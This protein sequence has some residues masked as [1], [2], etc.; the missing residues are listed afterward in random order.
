MNKKQFGI[1]A[2]SIGLSFSLCACTGSD[3]T[4]RT[5]SGTETGTETRD[6]RTGT[7][8]MDIDLE[9]VVNEDT[10]T[11][12]K[13]DFALYANKED[14]L[15]LEIREG[16][17]SAGT[18][19]DAAVQADED[20]RKMFL[21]DAPQGHDA[22]LAYN[23]FGLLMDW[24]SRNALGVSPLKERI[25]AVEAISSVDELTA[26]YLNT[27]IEK[28]LTR[29][30]GGSSAQDLT[31]S[32]RIIQFCSPMSLTLQDSAEYRELTE[33][34]QIR[35]DAAGTLVKKMLVKLGC[36]EE[37]AQTRFDNCIRFETMIAEA[38]PTNKE[39]RSP[40]YI[41]AVK[42]YYSRDQ[43]KE[44][45]GNVPV[46]E[47]LEQTAGYPAA[48]EYLVMTPKFVTKLNEL[49][50]EDNLQL[51]KDTIIVN[52][53]L[54]NAESLDREC[55]D[56]NTEFKNA[57]SGAAGSL[58]DETVMSSY[59]S[60]VLEW[61]VARLY[62]ENY[63]TQEDKDRVSQMIDEIII[64][65][66]GIINEAD[67]LSE[68]TRA[69]AIEKLDALK[70]N[71]LFPDDWSLYSCEEL[72]F[73]SKDEGGT[74]WAAEEA[75]IKYMFQQRVK[76]YSEPLD[77]NKWRMTPQTV[78]CFYSPQNNQIFILGAF[79]KGNV[80]NSAMSD[81]ELYAK[82]GTVIAHEISHAFDP[83]GAQ[84]DKDGNMADWWT[85][86]DKAAFREK[87]AKLAAYYNNMHPWE[88]QDFRGEIM[89]G[90]ACADM[91]GMKCMLRMAAK[92]ENFDY[93]KFFTSYANLYLAKDTM[94][95]ALRRIEDVHPMMYLRINGTLQQYDEFLDFYG[96][97]E[98]DNMYLA[99]ED[100]TA[101]W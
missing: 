88:G 93:D 23:L 56:W 50:T 77:K 68:A 98:G 99:P 71:A 90:E 58:D 100:R 10:P 21:G 60:S 45:E 3:E 33:Y 87:T 94:Q 73:K 66:H 9:G 39:Q 11:D 86:E 16:Y 28:Q 24:D 47:W 18:F 37:E 20:V 34:G 14:I 80:Y 7:P 2:V 95:R 85:E 83:T 84:F 101:I 40:E 26:Y 78:N 76:K 12:P 15:K 42:N 81:E 32:S 91:A 17:S 4:A 62:T 31:D 29:L 89:T 51:M 69:K 43:L 8:W 55:Y 53:V 63:L 13:D 57:L 97:S 5:E 36:S 1:L 67:F 65:Y 19:M 54:G 44:A 74:S 27:P 72:N 96:I 41:E 59:V 49:Y 46:I 38:I 52:G 92:K 70:Y 6:Y 25:D 82:L 64:E 30:W 75:I 79:A 48:D 61:P 35:K 22:L